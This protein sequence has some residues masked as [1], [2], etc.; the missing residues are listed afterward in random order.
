[1]HLKNKKFGIWGLG[2]VGKSALK[3]FS[4]QQL[5]VQVMDCK[6]CTP[7]EMALLAQH[8]AIFVPQEHAPAF[9]EYN[10]YI[11]VSP[12]IDVRTYNIKQK[13]ITEL[14]IFRAYFAKKII[15]ITGSIGK[16]SITY[17]LAQ[18]LGQKKRICLGG[19]IGTGMLDLLT[20]N[21]AEYAI[22]ETSSYQLEHIK[23][24]AP[25]LAIWTNFYPNH[26]DR[27]CTQQEYFLAKANILNFQNSNQQAL[28]PLELA[29]AI[30]WRN[31][32]STISFFASSIPAPALLQ[33]YKK[34][35]IFWIADNLV[36]QC[37]NGILMPLY[38]LQQLS[39]INFANN[40]L[41]VIAAI[42]LLQI[43]LSIIH[44]LDVTAL[45][46]ADT[47]CHRLEFCGSKN[48]IDFYNDSKSTIMESTLAAVNVLSKKPITLL[49]GGCSK[50][51]DRKPYFATLETQVKHIVCFG[52]EAAQLHDYALEHN[53]TSSK[54]ATLDEAFEQA[55]TI[56]KPG[57]QILLSPGGSS[58][59][60]FAN[61]QERG[62][63]FKK[64]VQCYIS[65]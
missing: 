13:L 59:D 22:L 5:S 30:V 47:L 19:N 1:M 6:L 63:A 57:E 11:L 54:A 29:T 23:N 33:K 27:H 61:Y 4:S 2:I 48:A 65:L 24:F 38:P 35:T 25:D 14:D 39:T 15:A 31:L 10:D 36:M 49:L 52:A 43:P 45:Q 28:I 46:R 62:N 3:F 21:Q 60:L 17:L 9:F 55:L 16:T 58:F 7:E 40:W 12:G 56:T 34:H 44:M 26:L 51:I 18:I 64:L 53:F 20:D 41:V 8:N 42:K 37:T 50:G 32:E